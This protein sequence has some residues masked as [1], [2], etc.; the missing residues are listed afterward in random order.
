MEISTI[1][2][3]LLKISK[4]QFDIILSIIEKLNLEIIDFTNKY[5]WQI[6]CLL[7]NKSI[8]EKSFW[9]D[10]IFDSVESFTSTELEKYPE[11]IHPINEVLDSSIISIEQIKE[12]SNYSIKEILWCSPVDINFR[13]LWNWEI[14]NLLWN[15]TLNN[16]NYY[17]PE[18]T[19][20]QYLSFDI[21]HNIVHLLHLYKIWNWVWSYFDSMTNRSFWESLAVLSEKT[22]FDLLVSNSKVS[23]DIYITFNNSIKSGISK[24]EF[25]DW[26]IKDR[27]FEFR[28]R[29]VRL[30]W[31][32][33]LLRGKSLEEASSIV[34]N[35]TKINYKQ[36]KN[37]ILKY[38]SEL[39]LWAIYTV[40]YNRLIDNWYSNPWEILN[41][42]TVPNTWQ[43]FN[44]LK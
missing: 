5:S 3:N 43:E 30:L 39:W 25:N 24:E 26:M 19:I 36:V 17:I 9:I 15:S 14:H 29:C 7:E 37:E 23:D 41:L 33:F 28:L 6:Q 38:I 40:W 35:I 10:W 21:P 8:L 44:A 42:K 34:C 18:M 13:K 11:T 4:K 16:I 27:S 32:Y 22:I 20:S 1:L 12:I 2:F 31:D